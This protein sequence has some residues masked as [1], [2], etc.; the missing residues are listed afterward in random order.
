VPNVVV[1]VGGGVQSFG[2]ATIFDLKTGSY[3]TFSKE[4]DIA[5]N[6]FQGEQS[7]KGLIYLLPHDHAGNEDNGSIITVQGPSMLKS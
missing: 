6:Q 1:D 4:T 2:S 3:A 7:Q 5:T